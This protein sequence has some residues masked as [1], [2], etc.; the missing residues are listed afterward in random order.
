MEWTGRL[1]RF[2]GAAAS[3]QARRL[4]SRWAFPGT[5]LALAASGGSGDCPG[6]VGYEGPPLVGGPAVWSGRRWGTGGFGGVGGAGRRQDGGGWRVVSGA[7]SLEGRRLG[8][9]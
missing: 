1:G 7:P 5:S 3:C 4:P 6:S 9:V 8:R 2:L